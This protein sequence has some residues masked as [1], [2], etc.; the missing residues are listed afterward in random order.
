MSIN[1]KKTL[2][3]AEILLA[4][5]RNSGSGSGGGGGITPTGTKEIT[6][7]ENG[8][9]E[10]D[11]TNF[12]TA[13]ITV[14][15][16]EPSGTKEISIGS[17][18]DTTEDVAAYAS[19]HISVNVP[20]PSGTT[21]ITSNGTHDV[22]SYASAEVNVPNPSAGTKEISIQSNGQTTEDVTDFASVHI[23][24]AVP[25]PSG[26]TEIE[27][28]ANGTTTH[29]VSEY[30]SAK[31]VVNVPTGGGGSGDTLRSVLDGTVA[32]MSDDQ[33][34]Y[35]REY[36]FNKCTA[37]TVVDLPALTET[38]AN[39]FINCG[40]LTDVNVP[41]LA[42]LGGYTFYNC[43]SL[44]SIELPAATEIPS[45]CF[46]YCI[47][48]KNVKAVSAKSVQASAF[49]NCGNLEKVE[50]LGG[51]GGRFNADCGSTSLTALLIRA[52]DGVMTLGSSVSF[53][54]GASIYVADELMESYKTATNWSKFADQIV[55]LS[56]YTE[57]E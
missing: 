11:V 20:G 22:A 10:H 34:T 45:S 4:A 42:T 9:T 8:T 33:L 23:T 48:L 17:N 19:A 29:D 35:L 55:A 51:N 54:D 37:L 41:L 47:T 2:T 31:I 43:M 38:G 6:I 1:N 30:A 28:A 46:G 49:A 56:T 18:G 13:Q 40:A 50:I 52:T 25:E 57:E 14:D 36:A 15:V 27:I 12:A 26:E 21:Q 32:A 24:T 39:A 7:E 16:P 53:P 3:P 5:V 44:Q